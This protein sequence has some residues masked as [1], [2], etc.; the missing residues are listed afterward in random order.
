MNPASGPS[1]QPLRRFDFESEVV[2]ADDATSTVIMR[3]LPDPRRYSEVQ[4]EGKTWF[5]DKY[6]NE[7][8]D[9]SQFVGAERPEKGRIPIYHLP[10]SVKSTEAYS[11][12]RGS[13]VRHELAT[14]E[15]SA[16]V[17]AALPHR[18]LAPRSGDW[19][20]AF[21]SVD[22]CGATALR[23][24]NAERFEQAYDLFMKELG[25]LV[26]H[27]VVRSSRPKATGS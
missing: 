22:I 17:E 12:A 25:A 24:A 19:V 14:G 1:D 13:A 6:L 20:L 9:L 15:Y 8:V 7:L 16:P 18:A 5:L 27:F 4:H 11:A 2:S 23:R 26:G 21:V 3:W 10:S